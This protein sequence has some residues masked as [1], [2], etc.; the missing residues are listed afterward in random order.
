ML[1]TASIYR[2]QYPKIIFDPIDDGGCQ[3]TSMIFGT[4][5]S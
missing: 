3:K 2:L 4:L 5:G 1:T